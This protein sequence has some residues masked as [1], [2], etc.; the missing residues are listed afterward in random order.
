VPKMIWN[1]PD[2]PKPYDLVLEDLRWTEIFDIQKVTGASGLLEI[3]DR[4][5]AADG[6]IIPALLWVF[7][8]REGEPTLTFDDLAMLKIRDVVM[9]GDDEAKPDEEAGPS[10]ETPQTSP[11]PGEQQPPA[12]ESPSP[13]SQPM[14][15]AN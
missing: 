6:R 13:Q 7:R 1:S 12:A 10:Q 15:L 5:E 2:G 8:K 3:G 11:P 14:R 9:E 4:L